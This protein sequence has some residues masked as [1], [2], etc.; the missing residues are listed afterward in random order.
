M[1]RRLRIQFISLVMGI[2]FVV[3]TVIFA[4]LCAMSYQQSV[5]EVYDALED[6]VARTASTLRED[7]PDDLKFENPREDKLEKESTA[8]ALVETAPNAA[9]D[10]DGANSSDDTDDTDDTDDDSGDAEAEDDDKAD[11][12][13]NDEPATQSADAGTGMPAGAGASGGASANTGAGTSAFPLAAGGGA[14]ASDGFSLIPEAF[15]AEADPSDPP[16]ADAPRAQGAASAHGEASPRGDDPAQDRS[17]GASSPAAASPVIGGRDDGAPRQSVIPMA[18]LLVDPDGLYATVGPSSTASISDEVIGET[19]LAV[20][21]RPDGTGF[22]RDTGLY[23]A[24]RTNSDG[25]AAIAFAD[26]SSAASWKS[27]A[28]L[29]AALE[30]FALVLFFIIGVFFSRW[31]LRPVEEAWNRQRRFVADAS[32]ELKTPLTVILANASILLKHADRTIASE[33]KW[34]ES[35]Q[36]EALHMQGLVT[37]ML[38]L[39][40]TESGRLGRASLNLLSSGDSQGERGFVDVTD[41]VEG[42]ALQFESVAFESGIAMRTDIDRNVRLRGDKARLQRLAAT[43]IDNACKYADAGGSVSVELKE[44]VRDVRFS[45]ENTGSTIPPEDLPHIFDR[46]YRADKARSRDIGGFGLGLAIAQEIAIDHGGRIT[47]SSDA[48][49]TRFEAV[50]PRTR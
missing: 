44:T 21:D 35:T 32:H 6:A 41:L 48:G 3:L 33:S 25:M 12:S 14:S 4:S 15:A 7:P 13:D 24:K 9:E 39:A 50:F 36:T 16:S 5:G 2:V 8:S 17:S 29:C 31:A 1:L 23:Y 18:V 43:L 40:S 28:L 27:L 38:E 34:V 37:E 45:V 19:V 49:T 30:L 10:S 20:K 42:E 11:N 22:A 46:F 47:A 26:Q